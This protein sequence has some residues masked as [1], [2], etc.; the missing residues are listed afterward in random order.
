M[1]EHSS[2]AA[3]DL[4][5]RAHRA[6]PE[7][8]SLD[9]QAG[10]ADVLDRARNLERRAGTP[11]TQIAFVAPLRQVLAG[12][13]EVLHTARTKAPQTRNVR[14]VTASADAQPAR[15]LPGD[16]SDGGAV[17]QVTLY[18]HSFWARLSPAERASVRDMGVRTAHDAGTV[19]CHQGDEEHH[20]LILLS[21]HVRVAKS[22]ADGGEIVVGMR[23][24]GDVLGELAALDA[25]PRSATVRALVDV[26]TLAVP[27]TRFARLC[28]DQPGIAWVLLGEMIDRLRESGRS[29]A[30]FGGG[31]TSQRIAAL[32][33]DLAIRQGKRTDEGVDIALWNGQQELA[34]GAATSRESVARALRTLRERHVISTRRGHITVH[35]IAELH[36]LAR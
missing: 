31:Q 14:V 26:E 25:R 1:F 20:V 24:P 9:I 34:A 23:G 17:D 3:Q 11:A 29:R 6:D 16:T 10:L 30:E 18:R 36:R 7:P 19:L 32:L 27:G 15:R 13:V 33:L 12:S 21:G 22:A 5:Q 4:V 2:D 35:N 8:A 28:R